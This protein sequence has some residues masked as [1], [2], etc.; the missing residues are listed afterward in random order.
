MLQMAT[1]FHPPQQ[2]LRR[3]TILRIIKTNTPIQDII[4]D[5]KRIEQ[6]CKEHDGLR[7]S[8]S[9]DYSLNIHPDMMSL[10]LL[11]EQEEPVSFLSL[12]VPGGGEAEVSACTMPGHRRKGYF[13][14]LLDEAG[15]EAAEY[16]IRDLLF[17][18]E[19]Q[20]RDGKSTLA[21]L[22]AEYR[23]T[24]YA[25]KYRGPEEGLESPRIP[26]IRLREANREDLEAV[27]AMSQAI[28]HDSPD[29]ARSWAL[30]AFDAKDRVQYITLL[31]EQSVEQSDNQPVGMAS[32]F[33]EE[34]EA[35]I[36][37]LGILPGY[38]G[39]GLGGEMLDQLIA[40]TKSRGIENISIEVDST[41]ESAFH[42]YT[43]HG[44]EMET[45]FEYHA[46]SIAG[47]SVRQRDA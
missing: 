15:R 35:W 42:L 6:A 47:L 7:G 4:R 33:T 2:P 37:G 40:R 27:I 8:V 41:N 38:Q 22:R 1:S 24:E 21:A 19:A 26:R 39:K 44:F 20:S 13:S 25:L 29:D 3:T 5:I 10:F 17:V 36:F 23:F 43:K 9:L 28:F 31:R 30:R 11:Y 34:G 14:L 45:A 46:K 12:F 18:C 16:G 32:V